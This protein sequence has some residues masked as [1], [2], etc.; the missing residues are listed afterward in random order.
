MYEK[1]IVQQL[2]ESVNTLYTEAPIDSKWGIKKNSD[3]KIF[4]VRLQNLPCRQ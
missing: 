2:T 4:L 3:G 1:K